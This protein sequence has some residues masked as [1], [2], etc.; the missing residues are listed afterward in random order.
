MA[1]KYPVPSYERVDRRTKGTREDL[2]AGSMES[3]GVGP[4]SLNTESHCAPP[5]PF[6][7][8]STSIGNPGQIIS[9][10]NSLHS[11]PRHSSRPPPSTLSLH[12]SILLR[13]GTPCPVSSYSLILL[14]CP[15][16]FHQLGVEYLLPAVLTLA[17]CPVLSQGDKEPP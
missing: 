8:L 4:N 6:Q 5:P 7:N 10:D 11:T 15:G 16:S 13:L 17:I 1:K 9:G 14:L 3:M 12:P 2:C